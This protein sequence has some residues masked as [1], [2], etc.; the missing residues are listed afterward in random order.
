MGLAWPPVVIVIMLPATFLTTYTIAVLEGHVPA[1]FPYISDTGTLPPES[2]IFGQLL[3]ITAMLIAAL[4][5]IRYKQV[6]DHHINSPYDTGQ[7]RA[8]N[9]YNRAC[10]IIGW[11]AALG[12]S[13][14]ANF[15]ETSVLI[16]HMIGAWLAFGGGT[17]YCW[18]H[19]RMSQKLSI[20]PPRLTSLRYL[21]SIIAT[22]MFISTSSCGI[23]AAKISGHHVPDTKWDPSE[24]GFHLHVAS[25][26]SEWF[27]AGAILCYFA[28]F[29][30][31]F[32]G[33]SLTHPEVCYILPRSTVTV[34]L[35]DDEDL[36]IS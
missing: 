22:L 24:P 12:I 8:I 27:I 2:C 6:Q 13:F 32:K 19:T 29:I 20:T 5:Y 17:M 33:L 4:I 1:E 35:Q 31:D 10:L 25:T 21:F 30:F 3:N 28:T 11:V 18:V 26:A 16:V 14:V 15:Q 36:L 7:G 9:R 34:N 23:A